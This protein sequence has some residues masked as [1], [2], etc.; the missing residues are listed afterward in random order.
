[1]KTSRSE[2]ITIRDLRHHVRHWG[3]E[4]APK[5]FMMHGWMD[6]SA[7]FQFL[8]DCL[9]KDWHVIAPDWRG[10]GQTQFASGH[11]YWFPDYVADL[12]AIL[13]H[14]SPDAPV[15]LLGHS[16][17]G[18]VSCIYAGVRPE[19][20]IKL[21]NLEGYGLPS[22]RPEEAP[23]R[24]Q[25]WLDELHHPPAPKAYASR[26]DVA[27]LLQKI[28]P[29]LSDGRAMF[30][31][32]HWAAPNAAGLWEVQADPMHRNS[33]PLLYRAEEALACWSGITA[34]V[35]W[36]EAEETDIWQRLG[37]TWS[38]GHPPTGETEGELI[39]RLGSRQYFRAEFDRR[40]ASIP[41]V[42][43]A[44]IRNS[45]HMVQHDQPEVVAKLIEDFLV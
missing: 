9:V 4:A 2:F 17:G 37:A 11:S 35:L 12:D 43:T 16:M 34:P 14:Y 18:N 7:S 22:S 21:V 6:M 31:S 33:S 8:V 36:V 20:I 10:F 23:F 5:L 25:H 40:M 39:K 32:G 24:Y 41:K 3:S 42:T 15:Y 1:M 45:G 19:R 27:A 29:R 28:N 30:L 44:L 13:R 26:A 38:V